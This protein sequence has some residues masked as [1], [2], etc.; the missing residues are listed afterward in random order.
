MMPLRV[1][2]SGRYRI[3]GQQIQFETIPSLAPQSATVLQVHVQG[4]M[5]G[6]QRFRAVMKSAVSEAL[7]TEE[8]T[9]VYGD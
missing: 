7:I 4:V 8:S 5:K 3:Q 6:T 1:E 9:E 2:S